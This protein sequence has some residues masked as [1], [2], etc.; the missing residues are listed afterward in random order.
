MSHYATGR[1]A[2]RGECAQMCRHLYTLTDSNGKTLAKDKY[3][4]SL[5]DLNMTHNLEQLIDAGISSFKIEGRLKGP[6]YVKN[7]TAHYRKEIDNILS[8]RNDLAASSIGVSK[9]GFA[10]DPEKSFN[11]L[12]TSYNLNSDKNSLANIHTPKSVGQ[13]IGE[14]IASDNNT[15]QI[16]TNRPLVNGDG[17]CFF[18]D[19][20]ELQGFRVNKVEG[21]KIFPLPKVKIDAN[22]I[23][24]RNKDIGFEKLVENSQSCRKIRVEIILEETE[25][26][27][28][29]TMKDE[30]GI[31]V[32]QVTILDKIPAKEPE[33]QEAIIR[34]NLSKL[35]DG[36]FIAVSIHIQFKSPLFIPGKI[37]S[38]LRR[39]TAQE[40]TKLRTA[41]YLRGEVKIE[42]NSYP[43]PQKEV[44]YEENI[45]NSKAG[46]FYK[47]H[48]VEKLDK[49]YEL[50]QA[51]PGQLLMT[52]K[53]CIRKELGL[54]LIDNA[55]YSIQKNTSL[56]IEDNTGKYRIEFDC[57]KC[58]MKIYS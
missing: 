36:I 18:N 50:Q 55:E 49:A 10:S 24:Y 38:E 30:Q 27:I 20:G 16:D 41:Q 13:K 7:I 57:K 46:Q 56:F 15:I 40:L 42:L 43:Y 17:L 35:G 4:L 44:L 39:N 51:I 29:L 48:G 12:F 6:E 47:R 45:S 19:L 33:K 26:G 53:Y 8:N 34:Q 25:E 9:P 1:S 54:C 14:V 5:K 58:E 31:E 52:T 28:A 37:I 2:N 21:N 11:R 3:L 23:L 22:T 32:E